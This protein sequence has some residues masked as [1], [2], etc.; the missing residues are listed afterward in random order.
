[1]GIRVPVP[2]LVIALLPI[3][4][5]PFLAVPWG[6]MAQEVLAPLS[7]EAPP[8]DTDTAKAA[9]AI[10]ARVDGLPMGAL[11][12]SV[13]RLESLGKD[14]LPA[15][16]GASKRSGGKARLAAAK[17]ILSLGGEAARRDALKE[18]AALARE[19][20]ADKEVRVAAVEV[21]GQEDPEGSVELVRQVYEQAA[22]DPDLLIPA[23]RILYGIEQDLRA[24]AA[25]RRNLLDLVGSR[26]SRVRYSAALAL[27]AM[28]AIE[29]EVREALRELRREPSER[30]R[31]AASLLDLDLA[32]RR[33]ERALD[34]GEKILPGAD[35]LK[36]LQ[37]KTVRIRELEAQIEGIAR[38][39]G[40][41]A[42]GD[43]VLEEIIEKIQSNYIDP[44][45]SR[46]KDLI[47]SAIKGMA[48]SLD[49]YSTFFD[50]EET[51]RFL[52]DIKGEYFGIGAQVSKL[53]EDG[54][55]EVV[56]P[57][58]GGGA[59]E[60]GIRTGDKIIE[61][62]GLSTEERPLEEIVEK[63]LKGPGGTT[64]AVKVIR[65]GWVEPR[66]FKIPRRIVGPHGLPR[67]AAGLHRVPEVDH[68]RRPVCRRLPEG[69]G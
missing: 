37:E 24:Q 17:A 28:D 65:R 22:G 39:R 8:A 55:L 46:R 12:D 20:E 9:L 49:D 29:G 43:P 44:E 67:E 66:D 59:Y 13:R 3:L 4:L 69:P 21:L 38:S 26:D 47:L 61:I 30:G 25:I 31:L 36:V 14:V 2:G 5:I 1:M 18:L 35:A 33:D 27:A 56:K 11:W 19:K 57:I 32:A 50:V 62:D 6:I 63:L 15:L 42:G 7:Q 34:A 45:K 54:P 58:Y 16:Q 10:L 64:V 48:R 41:S 40:G 68:L 51:D 53:A 60:C 23:A 52:K